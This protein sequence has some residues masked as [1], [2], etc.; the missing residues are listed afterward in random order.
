MINIKIRFSLQ[1][2]FKTS[3]ILNEI[4]IKLFVQEVGRCKV[5]NQ[6]GKILPICPF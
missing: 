2:I 1:T 5:V 4:K 6:Q 3:G